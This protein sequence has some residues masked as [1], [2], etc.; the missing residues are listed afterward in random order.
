MRSAI[1]EIL[2]TLVAAV[3]LFLVIQA[4]VQ[5]FQVEGP[6]MDPTVHTGQLLLVNKAIYMHAQGEAVQRF[7]PF[8]EVGE[9]Q[10]E[11]YFF[12]PPQ[13]GDIVV[14]RDPQTGEYRI[15]RVI[16][17]PGDL[18][19]IHRGKTVVNGQ[20]L[21]EPYAKEDQGDFWGPQRL[22]PN[23]YFVL[24]DNRP[25]SRD[26]RSTGLVQGQD[27]VGKAWVSFWPPDRLG[28]LKHDVLLAQPD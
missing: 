10:E 12:N 28:F 14:F 26:S 5:N 23:S 8:V 4:L 17:I 15:K 24:G 2:E 3:L 21:E 20:Q 7:L 16:A 25:Q 18:V 6:S 9:G 22:P 13:R 27:I 11:F 19:Q 1:R